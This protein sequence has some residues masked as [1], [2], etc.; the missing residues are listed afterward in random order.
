MRN[1]WPGPLDRRLL[2]RAAGRSAAR[3]AA[4]GVGDPARQSLVADRRRPRRRAPA[5]VRRRARRS[6]GADPAHARKAPALG[7]LSER[8]LPLADKAIRSLERKGFMMAEQVQTERD[9][10]AR[11]PSACASNCRARARSQLGKP[12]R[13][14][15]AFL[16]LHPGSHNLKDLEAWCQRQ[17]GRALAGAQEAG[18]AAH[19]T[20]GD[21]RRPVRAPHTL[22]PAQQAA[23]E[24][25]RAA[26][27]RA[28]S[29]PSCCTASPAPARPRST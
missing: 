17:P 8:K 16:E 28:N 29:A 11:R 22:N 18:D 27:R 21:H 25:D 1:C 13:E 10:C 5:S 19:R 9:P 3:H 7:R 26:I 20:A 14:L 23:F 24:P 12:E 2:L 6:G 4:A 15:L